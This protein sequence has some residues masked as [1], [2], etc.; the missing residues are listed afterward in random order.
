MADG[1]VEDVAEF[2]QH[3][4][5][6]P[7]ITSDQLIN[8][9]QLLESAGDSAMA[10]HL[11]PDLVDGRH[12][13]PVSWGGGDTRVYLRAAA[14]PRVSCGC[15]PAT[16]FRTAVCCCFLRPPDQRGPI[17]RARVGFIAR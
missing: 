7:V 10:A 12:I 6:E 1:L 8:R 13:L 9:K 16:C 14:V 11:T 3:R 5:S 2:R 4:C 17:R 15:R